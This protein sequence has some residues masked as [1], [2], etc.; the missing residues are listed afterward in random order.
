MTIQLKV[1]DMACAACAETIT[2]AVTTLDP[3]AQIKANLE[4]KWVTVES[5]RPETAIKAAIAD[6]G[7]TVKPA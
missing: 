7:Y 6:A 4:T 5:E 2:Q 1:P 3:A